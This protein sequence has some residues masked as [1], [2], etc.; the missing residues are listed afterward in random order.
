M[1][2]TRRRKPVSVVRIASR[3]A[4]Y[5]IAAWGT[6]GVLA[7]GLFPGALAALIAVAIYTTLPL[8]AYVRWRGWPFYPGKDFASA[9]SGRSGTRNSCYRSCQPPD[10][11]ALIGGAP[12][13]SRAHGGTHRRGCRA[14][15]RHRPARR[16][17][18]RVGASRC[19]SRGRQRPRPRARVR[20]TSHR[21]ALRPSRW[22][23]HVASLSR[24]S[25]E[26]DHRAAAGY[27]RRDWRLD[28]RSRR[29]REVMHARALGSLA[30]PLGVYMIP[31]N[32]DKCMPVGMTSS[33]T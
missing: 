31:G 20:G 18:L 24:P 28:R 3:L 32:H 23:A 22:P 21:A 17:L 25:R 11:S 12:F 29:G 16:G 26:C 27:D 30:A 9:S 6:L 7:S 15:N 4:L 14:H 8:L 10:Y 33:A 1:P 13:G 19:A 5:L 2:K